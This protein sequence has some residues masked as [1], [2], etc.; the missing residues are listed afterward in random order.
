MVTVVPDQLMVHGTEEGPCAQATLMSIGK[1][2]EEANIRHS[3]ALA[4]KVSEIGVPSNR[5]YVTFYD[6]LPYNVGVRGTT[7]RALGE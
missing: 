7:A 1:L 5:F 6:T 3:K 2:G 4:D